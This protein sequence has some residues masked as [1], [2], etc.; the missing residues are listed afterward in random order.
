M[1]TIINYK[2]RQAEDGSEF[3][4]LE[5]QGG[6]E[7][8]KSQESGRFYATAKKATISS[9]FDENTCASLIGTQMPGRIVKEDCDPY[10]YIVKE[11]G[12]E[13]TLSH[14]WVYQ[15]EDEVSQPQQRQHEPSMIANSEVFSKNGIL[16]PAE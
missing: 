13:L 1:V 8:V 10:T 5:L 11:T 3:F 6:I 16:E 2:E 14:R 4:A 12:E 7:M 15:P 9:T